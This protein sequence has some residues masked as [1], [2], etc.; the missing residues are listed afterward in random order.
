MLF[1][2]RAIILRC[3]IFL[4]NWLAYNFSLLI[5]FSTLKAL[6]TIDLAVVRIRFLF[7]LLILMLGGGIQIVASIKLDLITILLVCGDSSIAI[8]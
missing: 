2:K 1:T 7:L 3:G 6:R 8:E 5:L 4:K